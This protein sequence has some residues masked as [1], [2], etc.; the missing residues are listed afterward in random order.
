MKLIIFILLFQLLLITNTYSKTV[1]ENETV[2]NEPVYKL[3]ISGWIQPRYEYTSEF[4][5]TED[6][7]SFYIR[8]ARIDINGYALSEKLTYRVMSELARTFRLQDAWV[9]YAFLNKLQLRFGQFSVPFQWHRYSSARQ[10]H[11]AERGVPSET[12]GYLSGRDIGIM[13]HGK[14]SKKTLDYRLG[15][16]DGFGMN[17]QFSNSTG[18]VVSGRITKSILGQLKNEESDLNRSE[19][20]NLSV[21]LGIQAGNKNELRNWDLNRSFFNNTRAD[22][23]SGTADIHL[24]YKGFSLASDVYQRY[25]RP[26]AFEVEN[27]TGFGYMVSSGYLI[28]PSKLE[29]VARFS[30]QYLDVIDDNTYSQQWGAGLNIFLSGHN[31]RFK[32]HYLSDGS[33]LNNELGWGE[34]L[35]VEYQLV[36]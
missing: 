3:N 27:Y 18:H 22:F 20:L 30:E 34:R 2:S 28:I 15:F 25:V 8:R 13:L 6:L 33:M 9:N 19:S 4:G 24:T 35:I 5:A 23:L 7:S 10:Q 36:F 26:D 17:K 12:F 11:F 21:G 31:S 1:Q 16:F 29:I 14:N 32:I